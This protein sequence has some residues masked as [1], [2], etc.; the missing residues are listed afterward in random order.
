MARPYEI[1]LRRRVVAAIDEGMSARAA[2][3]RFSVAP[4]SAIKWRQQWRT[5]RSLEPARLG[6]P[7]GS[8][9]DAFEGFILDLVAAD[10]DIALHKIAARLLAEH[11][12]RTCPSTVWYFFAKRGLTHKKKQDTRQNRHAQTSRPSARS[13]S[14]ASSTLTRSV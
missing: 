4:S 13:G 7:P 6:H 8:K 1:E 14:T 2:A 12:V 9:L 3:A 11:G 5:E 10:K